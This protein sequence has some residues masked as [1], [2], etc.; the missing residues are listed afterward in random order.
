MTVDKMSV[1]LAPSLSRAVRDAAEQSDESLSGWL[2]DAA[3]TKLRA[4]ALDEFLTAWESENGAIT[5][6]ELGDAVAKLGPAL[7]SSGWFDF[8]QLTASPGGHRDL[9]AAVARVIEGG[10]PVLIPEQDAVDFSRADVEQITYERAEVRVSR[11]E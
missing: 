2:A 4:K 5:D 10:R 6:E 9:M 11:R 8:V 3:L 7:A 1:S